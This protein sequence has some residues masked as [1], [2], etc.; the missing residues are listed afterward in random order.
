MI[1]KKYSGA[2]GLDPAMSMP[3]YKQIIKLP[4]DSHITGYQY[5]YYYSYNGKTYFHSLIGVDHKD[6]AENDSFNKEVREK[7]KRKLGVTNVSII[8]NQWRE[9]PLDAKI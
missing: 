5:L 9:L 3:V 8:D 2:I 1:G 4:I 7:I 6:K